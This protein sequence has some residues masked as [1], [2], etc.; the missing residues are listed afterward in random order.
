MQRGPIALV[1]GRLSGCRFVR[2]CAVRVNGRAHLA[3]DEF[4]RR[5]TAGK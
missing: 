3:A 2:L 5:K 4:I 1:A